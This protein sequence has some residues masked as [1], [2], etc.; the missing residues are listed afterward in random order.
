MVLQLATPAFHTSG[1]AADGTFPAM[2][3]CDRTAAVKEQCSVGTIRPADV[4]EAGYLFL[5]ER[6]IWKSHD[7]SSEAPPV[8]VGLVAGD[9]LASSSR[10]AVKL[11]RTEEHTSSVTQEGALCR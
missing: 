6:Q 10:G 9:S 8:T 5:Q 3:Q 2:R 7:C 4:T 1:K 11:S